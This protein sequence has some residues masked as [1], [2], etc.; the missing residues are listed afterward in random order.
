[1]KA[2]REANWRTHVNKYKCIKESAADKLARLLQ[3]K[4]MLPK[5]QAILNQVRLASSDGISTTEA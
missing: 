5:Q 3:A 1:M 2:E 4:E